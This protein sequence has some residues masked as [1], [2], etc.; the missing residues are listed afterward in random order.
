M[1]SL[2]R[3][4]GPAGVA[5][6]EKVLAWARTVVPADP[7]AGPRTEVA[8]GG[9]RVV[10]PGE[11][12][13]ATRQA[14]HVSQAGR[15]RIP[16]EEVERADWD[17]D[18]AVLTVVGLVPF[19][20][21]RPTYLLPLADATRLL[22]VVRERVEASI[23]LQRAVPVAGQPGG[24]RLVGRCAPGGGGGIRWLLEFDDGVDPDDPGVKRACQ[25]A[26]E[27][28]ELDVAPR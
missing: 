22:D 21:V 20:Q 23:V 18:S 2:G 24:V 6:G 7:Q 1:R 25:Q 9:D 3:P 27:A 13:A 11:V 19:G 8:E 17:A 10:P 4:G 28:A 12:V 5:P 14:L 15:V 26:L 16:W